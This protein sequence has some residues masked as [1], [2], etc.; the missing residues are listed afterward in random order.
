[1]TPK[2]ILDPLKICTV[3]TVLKLCMMDLEVVLSTVSSLSKRSELY[4]V[5]MCD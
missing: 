2:L 1:M 3:P 4:H 5:S